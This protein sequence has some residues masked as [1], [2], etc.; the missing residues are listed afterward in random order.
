MPI[1]Q[2]VTNLPRE[3]IPDGFSDRAA[4]FTADQLGTPRKVRP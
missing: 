2:F 4:N 3:M 1:I